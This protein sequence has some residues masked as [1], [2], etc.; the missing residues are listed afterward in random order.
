MVVGYVFM[1]ILAERLSRAGIR[2]M[3]VAG[4][5]MLVFMLCQTLMILGW[6]LSPMLLWIVF[7][8]TGTSGILVYADLSQRFPA[9][10]AGR[11]NTGLNLLVFVAAFVAQW[12]VGAVIDL[13]PNTLTGY[14]TEGYRAGFGLLLSLQVIAVLWFFGMHWKIKADRRASRS[15]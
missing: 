1:G 6:R 13:W 7:G 11:V 2:P 12:G 8:F 4:T 9:D 3:T 14:A 10:L 5:G 15:N